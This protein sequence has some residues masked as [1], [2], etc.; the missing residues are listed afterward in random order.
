M[1]KAD[2]RNQ[3]IK[4][5]MVSPTCRKMFIPMGSKDSGILRIS[6]YNLIIKQTTITLKPRPKSM[7]EPST[8]YPSSCPDR[9]PHSL[10]CVPVLLH[11]HGCSGH[12]AA[13]STTPL[14]PWC[15]TGLRVFLHSSSTGTEPFCFLDHLSKAHQV[16]PDYPVC[17]WYLRRME[18]S[19]FS[20]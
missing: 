3:I 13:Q 1:S 14:P 20:G 6:Q 10:L 5:W 15:S 11:G 12:A 17:T 9:A 18:K 16:C 7:S 19:P 2:K 4:Q 8:L